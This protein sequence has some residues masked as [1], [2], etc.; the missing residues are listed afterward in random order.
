[1]NAWTAGSEPSGHAAGSADTGGCRVGR[2]GPWGRDGAS[3][4]HPLQTALTASLPRLQTRGPREGCGHPLF[5]AALRFGAQTP[6]W[7]REPS[8]RGARRSE[9]QAWCRRPAPRGRRRLLQPA[10]QGPGG[11][12]QGGRHESFL[13]GGHSSTETPRSPATPSTRAA[14][15]RLAHPRLLSFPLLQMWK[16]TFRGGEA[17]CSRPEPVNVNSRSPARPQGSHSHPGGGPR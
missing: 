7:G 17:T 14:L 8:L 10:T 3:F 1:M 16:K 15:N 9:S 13:P 5:V 4:C 2:A 6:R 12:R 11:A